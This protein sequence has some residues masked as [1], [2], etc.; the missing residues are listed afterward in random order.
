[1]RYLESA[2]PATDVTVWAVR[3]L[4]VMLVASAGIFA[5]LLSWLKHDAVAHGKPK[6]TAFT[7]ALASIPSSGL[8]MLLYFY[9][10]RA[11]R[12]ATVAAV[13]AGIG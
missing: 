7:Y 8:A 3:V 2:P 5:V 9:A 6:S 4:T 1:M 12:E 13:M 11:R 10:T